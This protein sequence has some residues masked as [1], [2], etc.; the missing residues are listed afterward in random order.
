MDLSRVISTLDK[1]VGYPTW[2]LSVQV[3]NQTSLSVNRFTEIG[4]DDFAWK[5]GKSRVIV[6]ISDA[7]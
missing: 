1:T 6:V 7:T 5:G 4:K 3:L 2:K